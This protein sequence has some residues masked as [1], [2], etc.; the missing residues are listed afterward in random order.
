MHVRR[1]ADPMPDLFSTATQPRADEPPASGFK[2]KPI[3][4]SQGA[5]PKH[6]LPK[7]LAG[8]LQ[9][10]E[11]REIDIL[12]AAVTAEADRRGRLPKQRTKTSL[13]DRRIAAEEHPRLTKGKLNA[14][15]AAFRA[16]VKPSAIARQFGISQS[17]VKKALAQQ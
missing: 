5:P 12:L 15:R 9:R 7:D 11:D 16:G 2:K 17:D 14:V 13:S 8:S 3:L 4:H 10:F 6:L 1:S